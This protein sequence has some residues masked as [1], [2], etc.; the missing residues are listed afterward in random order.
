MGGRG[1]GKIRVSILSGA[2]GG[3]NSKTRE[4]RGE[5]AALFF[6]REGERKQKVLE[7]EVGRPET[8]GNLKRTVRWGNAGGS[9]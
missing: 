9:K 5:K 1:E 6:G 2:I 3:R 7:E 4:T 8:E